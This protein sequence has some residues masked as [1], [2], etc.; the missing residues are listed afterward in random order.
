[1]NLRDL[2]LELYKQISS[3]IILQL[4]VYLLEVLRQADK[5]AMDQLSVKKLLIVTIEQKMDLDKD[6]H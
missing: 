3:I 4:Q 2:K 5:K 6:V 1:M